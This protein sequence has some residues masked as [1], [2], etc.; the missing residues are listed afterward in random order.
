ML[1]YHDIVGEFTYPQQSTKYL[2]NMYNFINM[3]VIQLFIQHTEYFGFQFIQNVW[4][5]IS[6]LFKKSR[7]FTALYLQIHI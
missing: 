1:L 3:C 4:D 2:L 5:F 7:I 6:Q